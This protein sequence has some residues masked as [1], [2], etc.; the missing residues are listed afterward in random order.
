MN[1]TQ[2]LRW[3]ETSPLKEICMTVFMFSYFTFLK[4]FYPPIFYMMCSF[5]V[6]AMVIAVSPQ[7]LI[8]LNLLILAVGAVGLLTDNLAIGLSGLKNF[9]SL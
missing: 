2:E 5:F 3:H 9:R 4:T 1:S 8:L 7:R 6:A